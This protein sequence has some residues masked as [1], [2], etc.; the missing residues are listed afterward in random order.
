MDK[1][2]TTISSLNHNVTM[3]DRKNIMISGVKK[4]DSFDNNR[5]KKNRK[6]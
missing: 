5:C 1:D 2:H 6:L 3:S 4:I